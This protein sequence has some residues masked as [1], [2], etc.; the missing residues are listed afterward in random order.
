MS[1]YTVDTEALKRR[2]SL[3]K[4]ARE[5]MKDV[6]RR[7]PRKTTEPFWKEVRHIA[8]SRLPGSPAYRPVRLP[9]SDSEAARFAR[10][11]LPAEFSTAKET[12]TVGEMLQTRAGRSRL[13]TISEYD[14]VDELRRF[15][16][17][18]EV[19]QKLGE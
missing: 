1:E 10:E 12:Q 4:R 16:Q 3:R 2:I 15:L 18:P 13:E 8:Q 6:I 11:Q 7:A 19:A 14:F 9:M 17:N 5:L